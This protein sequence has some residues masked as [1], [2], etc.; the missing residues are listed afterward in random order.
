MTTQ[1]D[2]ARPHNQLIPPLHH[3]PAPGGDSFVRTILSAASLQ[4]DAASALLAALPALGAEAA[5]GGATLQRGVLAQFRWLDALTAPDALT[6]G[7]LASLDG[8]AP[9]VA[10]DVLSFLPEVVPEGAADRVAA[11]LEAAAG[12]DGDLLLPVLECA[13]A[14]DLPPRGAAAV[15]R[16]ARGRLASAPL[17]A[18][19]A[20]A[21]CVLQSAGGGAARAG[22][23]GGGAG[24]AA[25]C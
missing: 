4:A 2:K 14:L 19:P 7:L 23:G 8:V 10:A 11:R 1:R 20:T 24:G 22:R 6:D 15:A 18:L 13:A 16:L 12:A 25:L 21:A 17:A 9:S 3:Q 5:D